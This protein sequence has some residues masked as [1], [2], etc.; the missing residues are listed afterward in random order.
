M[1]LTESGVTAGC[2]A[3][4]VLRR[5]LARRYPPTGV[6]ALG[7]DRTQHTPAVPDGVQVADAVDPGMLVARDLGHPQPGLRDADVDQGLDLES[8]APQPGAA[9]GRDVRFSIQAEHRDVPPPEGVVPV[10]QIGVLRPA[11][12]VD[13][14][15]EDPVTQAAQPGDIT[16]AAAD[17]E[18]C[19]LGEIRAVQQG[20]DEL[21]DLG[22]IGRAVGVDHGDDV[23]GRRDEPAGQGVSLAAAVLGDDPDPRAQPTGGGD[24]VVD[25]VPVDNDDLVQ[26]VRQLGE[27]MRQVAG[28]VQSGNDHRDLRPGL[29]DARE[30]GQIPA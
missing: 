29:A 8:V 9:A 13:Q 19:A 7:Q 27:D 2:Q 12:H 4:L 21:R 17:G 5:A 15:A 23:P 30:R 22:R 3:H 28:L 11:Q 26:P 14:A 18:P 16:A 10:A 1:W 25:G 6:V 20:P 24:G